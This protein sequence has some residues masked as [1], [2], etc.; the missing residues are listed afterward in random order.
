MFLLFLTA[1]TH[2]LPDTAP[3]PLGLV[4]PTY[5]YALIAGGHLTGSSTGTAMVYD[6]VLNTMTSVTG[7][8]FNRFGHGAAYIS[9]PYAGVYVVSGLLSSSSNTVLSTVERYS[10]ATN[11]WT[12]LLAIPFPRQY[13]VVVAHMGFIYAIGGGSGTTNPAT[14]TN[15]RY[16]P[17]NDTWVTR[18]D[19]PAAR[20]QAAGAR[21]NN[22]IY[23]SGG[24]GSNNAFTKTLFRYDPIGDTWLQL[25]DMN[26]MRSQHGMT[27][28][29]N[30]IY[31]AG[32][33]SG[34]SMPVTTV[35]QYSI[36]ADSWSNVNALPTSTAGFSLVTLNG[37]L[38]G[39]AGRTGSSNTRVATGRVYDPVTDSWTT[40]AAS[41]ASVLGGARSVYA[42]APFEY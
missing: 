42:L 1:H 10:P 22:F 13:L 18:A 16:D 41:V 11:N 8:S 26:G 19:M 31:V 40:D 2:T 4:E 36:E 6:S 35:E 5:R 30:K 9:G 38:F 37:R 7:S 15:Q 39:F 21:I 20:S 29:R 33:Y 17:A 12:S 25:T 32:G 14:A 24:L 34:S 23:V 3:Q 28:Y 27:P